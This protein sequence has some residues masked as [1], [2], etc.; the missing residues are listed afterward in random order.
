MISV[1]RLNGKP[2]IVNALLIETVED[3]PD[4]VITLT[5]GKKIMVLEKV[6][7]VIERT[8]AYVQSIG[9][10]WGTVKSNNAEGS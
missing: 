6:G 8:H 4:T 7:E 1:T 9:L 10:L 5:N 2:I 3:T